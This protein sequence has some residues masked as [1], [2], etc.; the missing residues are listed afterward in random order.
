MYWFSST[1][2]RCGFTF[3]IFILDG[4]LLSLAAVGCCGPPAGTARRGGQWSWHPADA[5]RV[6]PRVSCLDALVNGCTQSSCLGGC[7]KDTVIDSHVSRFATCQF[8]Q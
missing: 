6:A 3:S 1:L 2:N 8:D 7:E 4:C 5:A